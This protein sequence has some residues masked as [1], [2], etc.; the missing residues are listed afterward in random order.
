MN[1]LVSCLP[2]IS[3]IPGPRG[4][5]GNAGTSG[6]AG[7]NGVTP[8]TTTTSPFTMPA[9]GAEVTITVGA[10]SWMAIGM[11]LFIETAGNFVVVTVISGT[12]VRV[13]AQVAAA[14]NAVAGTVIASGKKVVT[15]AVMTPD[16]SVTDSLANRITVLE[17]T[18]QG[19]RSWYSS[20]PPTN[21]GGQLRIGDLW[22]DEDDGFKLY[23]WDGT[24]WDD[25][26]RVLQ[27]T[28]FGTG[29]RPIVK[30]DTLP[31]SGS[32]GDFVLLT[33]DNKLYRWTGA[34]WSKAVASGDLVGQIDGSTMI[35]D[36]TIIAQKLG[37][38][39]VT[40][41]KVG[42]NQIITS[43]ANIADA[44]ITDA[45]IVALSAGKIS[46]GQMQAV[47][48]GHNGYLFH[49]TYPTNKFRSTDLGVSFAD[50]KNFGSGS[51]YTFSHCTPVTCYGPGNA[52][53]G[54]TGCPSMCPDP[55][56]TIRVQVQGRLIGYYGNIL[57]YCRVNNGSYQP[58]ASRYSKDG[59]DAVIDCTRL[60]TGV[61]LTSK[62][63][64]F[65]A[66]ADAN[67]DATPNVTCR[68]EIDVMVFN[69]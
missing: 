23:R 40:A 29:I 43:A 50:A 18:S 55:S 10:T 9:G 37:A 46:A 30:V 61:T 69:W 1:D 63:E 11:P 58:L 15:G 28:D 2:R 51:A 35:V 44:T 4:P 66:P 5:A 48:I 39:S 32:V 64:I 25:V 68:Y 49:P 45:K 52:A 3:S 56:N 33:T 17:S 62:L 21:T 26:Q 7:T 16:S 36:G 6:S 12:T 42:A 57:V 67:G 41:A 47:D 20:T 13:A 22:F 14:G 54:T 31:L 27:L 8:T 53:F 59:N 24:Q 60:L 34:A 65:V 19:N 38:N